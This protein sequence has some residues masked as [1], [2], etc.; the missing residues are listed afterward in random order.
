MQ[1]STEKFGKTKYQDVQFQYYSGN[2]GVEAYYLDYKGFYDPRS[3]EDKTVNNS[4]QYFFPWYDPSKPMRQRPDIRII[5]AGGTLFH[6]ENEFPFNAAFNMSERKHEKGGSSFI[7]GLCPSYMRITADKALIDPANDGLNFKEDRGL[8]DAEF[9]S[10][11]AVFGSAW[12]YPGFFYF[13]VMYLVGLGGQY[14]DY[15]VTSGHRT[16]IGWI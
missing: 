13:N 4:D 11:S 6:L 8:K 9:Y 7:Y 16:A 12:Y 14:Q 15:E 10:L 5:T 2:L 3:Y 1:K